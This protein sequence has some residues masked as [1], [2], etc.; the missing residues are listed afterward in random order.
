MLRYLNNKMDANR[1]FSSESA[2][3]FKLRFPA[4]VQVVN[5]A[6]A[7]PFR[8]RGVI[9]SAV[10]EAVMITLLEN[11]GLTAEQLAD[12]Y[13]KLLA[14]KRFNDTTRGGTTDTGILRTRLE[15]ARSI[16]TNAKS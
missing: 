6:L 11:E 16:L 4:V 13:P 14:D 12:R 2:E 10:L 15:I 8:P 5:E 1:E 3:R 7:R 9:N